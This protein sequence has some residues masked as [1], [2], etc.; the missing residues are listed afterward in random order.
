[1]IYAKSNPQ[2]SM[3]EHTQKLLENLEILKTM[4]GSRI[5]NILPNVVNKEQFWYCVCITAFYHDFG[6]AFTPFQNVIR[7]MIGQEKSYS[8]FKNDIP[9]GYLSPAFLPFEEM[10]HYLSDDNE[11]VKIIIQAIAFHHE[12]NI[13]PDKGHIIEVISKDLEPQLSEINKHM[14][15]NI[16]KLD[17]FYL[18]DMTNRITQSHKYYHLYVLIKGILH[19][20]DHASSAHAEV[21]VYSKEALNEVTEKHITL[22]LNS[23]LRDVQTY[24]RDNSHK[25]LIIVASTGI[26]KTEA[27]LMW[28]GEDK[29]FFTL[30]LRVSLN[31][32]YS[33][34][35]E[36]INFDEVGLLHSTALDYLADKGYEDSLIIYEQSKH[37]AKKLNFTTVDQIFPFVF[38]YLGYEKIYATLAY[39]KIIV[40]EI[41]AYSPSM[42]ASIIKGLEM[43]YELN[44][45]FLIMTATFPRI[46]KDYLIQK[47]IP[48]EEKQFLS[49]LER[50]FVT[51]KEKSI[52]DDVDQ[53]IKKSKESK[54][55]VLANTVAKTIEI[56][57]I[58]KSNIPRGVYKNVNLLHSLFIQRDR[59][60]K[61]K[62]IQAFSK[63]D[64][65]GIWIS[66][67]IVEASLDV[68][69]DYLFTE[70]ST[71]DSLFQRFGRCY[72][73]RQFDLNHPNVYIYTKNVSGVGY[74]YNKDIWNFSLNY[75]RDYDNKI[76]TESD[77]VQMVDQLYSENQ[78]KGTK[79]LEEFRNS[80][81]FLDNII[82]YD[83]RKEEVQKIFRDINTVTCIPEDIYNKNKFLFDLCEKEKDKNSLAKLYSEVRKLTVDVPLYKAKEHILCRLNGYRL[84]NIH[85]LKCDY[86]DEQGIIFSQKG[87]DFDRYI[88]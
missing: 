11:L 45:K 33:R 60:Q 51:I 65:A 64:E 42:A 20:L 49:T 38:K 30:P 43:I 79:F 86:N 3:Y 77:K 59:A 18:N 10:S 62:D 63:S 68:D 4:Y 41:Q 88:L 72:R 2:E 29:T 71:L 34:V 7:E 19:R 1:M 76:V 73:N 35:K 57:N 39:S 61:E 5:E 24:A 67:Q 75:L 16:Q 54:V 6:K 84:N 14:G 82:D 32:L 56:Y 78:L 37:L 26:G 22:N 31:S 47:E 25:N 36:T 17:K 70:M 85:L 80:L 53:I 69:F 12:R 40:D 55:L 9:H 66:T 81:N 46:Y 23:N 87:D 28:A 27:A 74:V 21:E 50:H 15:T 52:L 13:I 44:G 8:S 48:F 83:L 58:L